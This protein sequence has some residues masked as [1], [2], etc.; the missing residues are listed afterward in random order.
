MPLVAHAVILGDMSENAERFDAVVIGAS[1][2]GLA[3]AGQL[4]GAGRVLLVDRAPPGEG[5]TSACGTLLAVLE[6]LDAL[7]ALE[8]VHPTLAINAAGRRMKV[9]SVFPFA[10]FDYRTL[11]RILAE[12]LDG[13][14]IAVAPFGG[15]EA[16]RV[17]CVGD[18]RVTAAVLVD[19][20]GSRALLSRA[21]GAPPLSDEHVS[22]GLETRHGHGGCDL[23]F[24]VRPE[25]RPDGVFW[26]FPAGGQVRE[27]VASYRGETRGLRDEL[28]RFAHEDQFPARAVHGG[29]FPA[30]LGDPVW[31]G[32]F[33]VGDAA[34]QCLPLTGEGIRPA[35][36]FGQEAGRRAR[37]VLE[38]RASLD[39]ALG[40]YRAAVLSHR[41][42]YR[43]LERLQTGMLKVPLWMLP[44]VVRVFASGPLA[45]AVQRS[46]WAVA[47]PDTLE[48]RPGV[49]STV[50]V[51]P[52][53]CA[54]GPAAALRRR[55][56]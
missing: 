23:E 41:R 32:V 35:L 51:P 44:P 48:V 34:G 49:R 15:V 36:V 19:A 20:S 7:E 1:F 11:C 53:Q 2:A 24:W 4:A 16:G 26:A 28:A 12:R 56:T 27:G 38:G 25:E 10:T 47:D 43:R 54:T 5:E 6:R 33:V 18:R 55:T 46:Y 29:R 31:A 50:R 3:A 21:L 39:E 42:A 13:V 52:E 8:Q 37:R 45:R 9:A 22:F 17:L 40:G 30:R 14:E